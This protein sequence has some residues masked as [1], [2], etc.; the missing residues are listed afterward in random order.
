MWYVICLC[1]M[2]CGMLCGMICGM[3]LCGMMDLVDV[4]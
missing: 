4:M 1:D 2:L 3:M